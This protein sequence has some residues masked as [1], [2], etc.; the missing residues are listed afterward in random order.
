MQ[1]F[2]LKSPLIWF[3]IIII[4]VSGCK[5]DEPIDENS[6]D[7]NLISEIRARSA[8]GSLDFFKLP[9]QDSYSELNPDS[10]YSALP[11]DP[12]NPITAEKVELGKNLYH[13]TLIGTQSEMPVCYQTYSCASCHH[14]AASFQSGLAQGIGDGGYGFGNNGDNRQRRPEYPID[15]VDIQQL[16]SPTVLNCAY[17]NL[18]LW[19]GQFGATG[20]NIGTESNW[21]EGTPKETNFM[22]YQG[23][24]TQAVAG[25]KVHKLA[26]GLEVLEAIPGYVQ[27]FA[28]A[29]PNEPP[30]SRINQKNVGLAI[31]AYERTIVANEAPFQNWLNGDYNAMSDLEKEGALLFFGKGNCVSCHTGPALNKMDFYALGMNDLVNGQHGIFGID[32]EKPDHK[33]RGGFTNRQEDMYKFK[34]PQLYNLK[35]QKYLGHGSQFHS[36]R[37][38]INYKNNAIPSNPNVPMEQLAEEFKPLHLNASEIDAIT[39]FI[40][41][42][43]YD[44]YLERYLPQGLPSGNCFPN[45]D[46]LSRQQLGCD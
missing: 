7:Q 36:V 18:M 22:G 4:I 25:L 32:M 12:Q 41:E 14:A 42:A 1:N 46:Q 8:D 30:Q 31:A 5:P 6:L 13:E 37:E 19:N 43:L 35:G 26:P 11:S 20:L 40:E 27:L 45:N 44:P 10:Y 24:E 38:I 28:K 3:I 17:Q 29:F 16:K 9:L 23:V 39:K 21:T 33:G 15:K 2:Y 34:V